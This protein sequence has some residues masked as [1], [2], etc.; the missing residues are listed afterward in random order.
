MYFIMIS[1]LFNKLAS[2]FADIDYT[3]IQLKRQR[4]NISAM[5]GE[6]RKELVELLEAHVMDIE[7][8]AKN[9]NDLIIH[10]SLAQVSETNV[11]KIPLRQYN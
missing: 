3:I 6:E 9:L 4:E 11:W 1:D 10:L 2:A 5:E 7:I 8:I